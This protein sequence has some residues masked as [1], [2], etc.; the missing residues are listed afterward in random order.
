MGQCWECT[1]IGFPGALKSFTVLINGA[2]FSRSCPE[3]HMETWS[4]TRFKTAVDYLLF[5]EH[6]AEALVLSAGGEYVAFPLLLDGKSI[7]KGSCD[8]KVESQTTGIRCWH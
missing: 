3:M 8:G 4:S 7:L 2:R 6:H 1:N 5:D